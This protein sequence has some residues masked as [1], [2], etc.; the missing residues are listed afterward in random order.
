[1]HIVRLSD[2]NGSRLATVPLLIVA[3]HCLR[4]LPVLSRVSALIAWEKTPRVSPYGLSHSCCYLKMPSTDNLWT[5]VFI[6]YSHGDWEVRSKMLADRVH[7]EGLCFVSKRDPFW[8]IF[9]HRRAKEGHEDSFVPHALPFPI[10]L[11]IKFF[12][13][14]IAWL[15]CP[16]IPFLLFSFPLPLCPPPLLLCLCSERGSPLMGVHKAWYIKLK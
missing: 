7:G 6:C 4:S 2:Q 13:Y 14:F 8:S 1:M 11:L 10:F 3:A 5:T 9:I 16:L 15:Q 12:I